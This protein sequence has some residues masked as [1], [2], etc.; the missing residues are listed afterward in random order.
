MGLL[1]EGVVVEQ[2]IGGPQQHVVEVEQAPAGQAALVG[3]VVSTTCVDRERH[4]TPGGH[5]GVPIAVRGQAAGLG[6]ADLG[7]GRRRVRPVA[8]HLGQ[9]APP[10]LDQGGWGLAAVGRPTAQKGQGELMDG[11][12]PHA[13]GGDAPGPLGVDT[14][15]P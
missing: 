1:G 5:R 10:L 12:G 14:G 15:T 9:Q 7:V 13:G 11:S 3:G 4:R 6:P 2:Q 8:G